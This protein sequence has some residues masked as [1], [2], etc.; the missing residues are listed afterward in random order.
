[1]QSVEIQRFV[2]GYAWR[3]GV[4]ETFGLY[5]E[6]PEDEGEETEILPD[7]EFS[8]DVKLW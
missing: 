4:T 7:M 5:N 1:L 3:S 6:W 8:P 2:D